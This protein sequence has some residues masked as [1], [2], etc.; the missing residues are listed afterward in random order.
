M[1][2]APF[3]QYDP[4][5]ACPLPL[6]HSR[7]LAVAEW[8]SSSSSSATVFEAAVA[9]VASEIA[10]V[11]AF[12]A[13]RDVNAA[14]NAAFVL[15]NDADGGPVLPSATATRLA[16]H[17][18]NLSTADRGQVAIGRTMFESDR[19]PLSWV[20]RLAF[21]DALW[22]PTPFHRAAFADTI[23][24]YRE[25]LRRYVVALRAGDGTDDDP[26]APDVSN[27]VRN[28]FV[29]SFNADLL[30]PLLQLRTA[31]VPPCWPAGLEWPPASEDPNNRAFAAD[32]ATA[33]DEC[34]A[35]LPIEVLPETIALDQ[36][37]V[38]EQNAADEQGRRSRLLQ[39]LADERVDVSRGAETAAALDVAAECA[40]TRFLSVFKW[41][42]RK[43][44]DALIEAFAEAFFV[45][46]S[47]EGAGEDEAPPSPPCLIIK[48][49]KWET[50]GTDDD[51]DD[52]ADEDGTAMDPSTRAAVYGESA[53]G[54]YEVIRR[55]LLDTRYST[56]VLAQ[57][58]RRVL[59]QRRTSAAAP[60]APSPSPS[61]LAPSAD[62][63]AAGAAAAEP[64]GVLA[65][66]G[67]PHAS[68]AVYDE[69]LAPDGTAATT[70]APRDRSARHAAATK[71]VR[72]LQREL[73]R[74]READADRLQLAQLAARGLNDTAAIGA[75]ASA[76]E[77]ALRR[78]AQ[79][80]RRR[81]TGGARAAA[82]RRSAS[83]SA[84]AAVPRVLVLPQRLTD[85]EMRELYASVDVVVQ[86]TRGEGWGRPQ[87]EAMAMGVPV[88]TTNWSAPP[89]YMVGDGSDGW[90]IPVAGT[91]AEAT[92]G[93]RGHRFAEPD[94]G[95]LV[96]LLRDVD[97]L[98]PAARQAV[99][100]R[101][102]ARLAREFGPER[103]GRQVI[104]LSEEAARRKLGL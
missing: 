80:G 77:R 69:L 60:A 33:V 94:V 50:T 44:W 27:Y 52:E 21:M 41:E 57:L 86:P 8:P 55:H 89:H 13:R 91:V 14:V 56:K 4:S 88:I 76:V 84:I 59:K 42:R 96:Q 66:A 24:T 75:M 58:R 82:S 15:E 63:A 34:L 19:V 9:L 67:L 101:A 46:A 31:V 62:R 18:V 3:A 40:G 10:E 53:L 79:S 70:A 54:Y 37:G 98:S 61:P 83:A 74:G 81:Y 38:P 97:R 90:L 22:V 104:D 25:L 87:Q 20:P 72:L 65:G 17:W 51:E 99:G 29:R 71:H 78:V 39:A 73:R 92:G 11:C 64:A 100:Q 16:A 36:W 12:E 103:V 85:V 7:L 102:R 6:P 32:V 47:D 49:S 95:S 68:A 45:A 23:A 1:W 2:A 93:L 5:T 26:A 43:G 30:G 28:V 48:T 35:R